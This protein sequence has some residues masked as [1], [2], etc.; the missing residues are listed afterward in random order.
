MTSFVPSCVPDDFYVVYSDLDIGLTHPAL[1]D[2]ETSRNMSS[3]P[4]FGEKK[5]SAPSRLNVG[6]SSSTRPKSVN[7]KPKSPSSKIPSSPNAPRRV[8]SKWHPSLLK[9]GKERPPL[10]SSRSVSAER[11]RATRALYS[12]W[13]RELASRSKEK[14]TYSKSV[15]VRSSPQPKCRTESPKSF[16]L[17]RRA[18]SESKFTLQDREASPPPMKHITGYSREK[19]QKAVSKVDNSNSVSSGRSV[20]CSTRCERAARV[21]SASPPRRYSSPSSDNSKR[22]VSP[23]AEARRPPIFRHTVASKIKMKSSQQKLASMDGQSS[24]QRSKSA[25]Y[26]RI[27][28]RSKRLSTNYPDNNKVMSKTLPRREAKSRPVSRSVSQNENKRL[29]Q[30]ESFDTTH[31]NETGYSSMLDLSP[32]PSPENHTYPRM[33]HKTRECISKES[34]SK[35]TAVQHSTPKTPDRSYHY[36]SWSHERSFSRRTITSDSYAERREKWEKLS[37][38]DENS[39]RFR[40][41]SPPRSITPLRSLN[42]VRQASKN[43]KPKEPETDESPRRSRSLEVV[44][45]G[46]FAC[47]DKYRQYIIELRLAA[48][49]NARISNLRRLFSSLDRAHNLERSISSVDLSNIERKAS[50]L[51]G[52]DNWK[53]LRDSE[54]NALE[55]KLL[56]NELNAAQQSKDFLFNVTHEK[57][58]TG[59]T[60]LRGKYHSVREIRE[61]FSS[62][63]SR[64]SPTRSNEKLDFIYTSGVYKGLWRGSSVRNL[65]KSLHESKRSREPFRRDHEDKGRRNMGLWTSLSLEQINALK[66]QLNDIYSSKQNIQNWRERK[67]I[68]RSISQKEKGEVSREGIESVDIIKTGRLLADQLSK[69]ARKPRPINDYESTRDHSPVAS[70][71]SNEY[72]RLEAERK[73]LSKQLSV[74]LKEKVHEQRFSD[75]GSLR[76]DSPYK[77]TP[78][79]SPDSRTSPRT[80]YSLDVSDSSQPSSLTSNA[81]DQLLLVLQKPN[82]SRSLPPSLHEDGESSDSDGSVRTVIHKDVAGK[83]KYFE[84]RAKKQAWATDYPSIQSSGLSLLASSE[85]PQYSA[86]LPTRRSRKERDDIESQCYIPERSVS[87]SHVNYQSSYRSRSEQKRETR[88]KVQGSGQISD[89]KYSR[90]YLKHVKTGD[91]NKL[92]ERYE[93]SERI[94]QKRAYSLP[95]LEKTLNRVTP[96]NKTVIRAQEN[97]D[98]QFMRQKYEVPR[99]SR[100]PTRWIPMRDEY[101]PKSK[102]KNTLERL[103]NKCE[104]FYEPE[105]IQRIGKRDSVEKKVLKRVHTG[106]VES[107]VDRIESTIHLDSNLSILGQIYTSSPSLSELKDMSPLVPPRPVSPQ[108]IPPKKPQRMFQ[109]SSTRGPLQTSTPAVSPHRTHELQ[110][111]SE[112]R[113]I[114][115]PEMNRCFAG[116]HFPDYKAE[117]HQPK[118]R[119][120]PP[121]SRGAVNWT[122][123]LERPKRLVK[124]IAP[125]ESIPSSITTQTTRTLCSVA[126]Y[127]RQASIPSSLSYCSSYSTNPLRSSISSQSHLQST[128][129]MKGVQREPASLPHIGRANKT[130]PTFQGDLPEPD[131]YYQY[132]QR[133]P[134]YFRSLSPKRLSIE[135]ADHSDSYYWRRTVNEKFSHYGHHVTAP[136]RKYFDS[137]NLP[138]KTQPMSLPQTGLRSSSTPKS[139]QYSQLSK[140]RDCNLTAP[141]VP[142]RPPLRN[143]C[144]QFDVTLPRPRASLQTTSDNNCNKSISWKGAIETI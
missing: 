94:D 92:K 50:Y 30:S 46:E 141:R 103:S 79:A 80:C 135:D 143:T 78:S 108:I 89:T 26:S 20:S 83:V 113:V 85:P 63:E 125:S 123:S 90:S 67:K 75:Y 15:S 7:E 84:K 19:Y 101:I 27:Q 39:R 118:S 38:E 6:T 37:R 59:D 71:Q 53:N 45:A 140:T 111:V 34:A 42:L 116:D 61:R 64:G 49:Q 81:D 2:L 72:K 115:P 12:T 87:T 138:Y 66:D 35:E 131:N 41:I 29:R 104:V 128:Y 48:P 13:H 139:S 31:S 33:S 73:K 14:I 109:S 93:S 56:L 54:R 62:S 96:D 18:V 144:R 28:A 120:I 70:N 95:N 86:T 17:G 40:S 9:L 10:P 36:S 134:R 77:R 114:T 52:Y 3:S 98:V 136:S 65:A 91:V 55:Y 142:P 24:V 97:G 119:Y 44:R 124:V 22:T 5:K 69:I 107:T 105:T 60:Y 32:S 82:R 74:E 43:I 117:I 126:S 137:R 25:D 23:G 47:P 110:R 100:S 21:L 102:I 11:V 8:S 68:N 132:V 106:I 127:N 4:T 57:K 51:L 76:R 16:L 129:G 58:W 88:E 133:S 122:R 112:M 130:S 99:R 121:D 1:S